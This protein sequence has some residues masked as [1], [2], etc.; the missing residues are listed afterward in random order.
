MLQKSPQPARIEAGLFLYQNLPSRLAMTDKNP[1]EESN[2]FDDHF[3]DSELELELEP[4]D[5]SI[6]EHHRRRTIQK[7]RA[8][9]DAVDLKTLFE[10]SNSDE[11]ADPIDLSDFKRFQFSI[12]H[13]LIATALLSV[14]MTVA[15]L[16][17]GFTAIFAT[18]A[19]A[20]ATGWWFVIRS[21]RRQRAEK[22]KQLATFKAKI[23]AQRAAEDGGDDGEVEEVVPIPM[24]ASMRIAIDEPYQEPKIDFS[25]SLKEMFGAFTV[26]AVVLSLSRVMGGPSN[27]AMLLGMIALSGLV[28][29]AVGFDPPRVVILSWWLM[30]VLYLF[31]SVWAAFGDQASVPR[32]ASP[33][34]TQLL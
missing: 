25:F 32:T 13:L 8:A 10:E 14:I 29:H 7:T 23:A 19:A 27:A 33:S 16:A 5:P 28:L 31:I 26:A 12:R 11:P 2:E 21:E 20:V 18:I 34:K 9:E 6:E 4:I 3:D 1:P 17:G 15:Q 22:E 30:L 24:P